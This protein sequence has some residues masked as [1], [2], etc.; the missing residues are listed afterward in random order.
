MSNYDIIRCGFLRSSRYDILI[1][2]NYEV[3]INNMTQRF[4]HNMRMVIVCILPKNPDFWKNSTYDS[5]RCDARYIYIYISCIFFSFMLP[6]VLFCCLFFFFFVFF[7]TFSSSSTFFFSLRNRK[8]I[9]LENLFLPFQI[10]KTDLMLGIMWIWLSL[11]TI[12]LSIMYKKFLN[13]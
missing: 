9:P 3:I 8:S 13:R 10:P 2:C 7:F 4:C 5:L 11:Q 6:S 12:G 1:N